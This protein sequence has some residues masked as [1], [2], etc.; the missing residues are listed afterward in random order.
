MPTFFLLL[1][2]YIVITVTANCQLSGNESVLNPDPATF[3]DVLM[4]CT[5][6]NIYILLDQHI[7]SQ[8]IIHASDRASSCAGR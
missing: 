8:G 4:S 2:L 7:F 5:L 3:F 6:H 1:L